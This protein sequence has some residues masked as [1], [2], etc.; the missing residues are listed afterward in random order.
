MIS[1]IKRII[2]FFKYIYDRMLSFYVKKS[3]LSR[4]KTK[5][6]QNIYPDYKLTKEQEKE[7]DDF[8]LENYGTKIPYYSHREH[9]SFMNK[10]HK[11]YF[12]EFIF[13]SETNGYFNLWKEYCPVLSDKNVLPLI[14]KGVG[15]NVPKQIFSCVRGHYRNEN[16]EIITQKEFIKLFSNSGKLFCK[17]SVESGGGNNCFVVDMK[18]GIDEINK[19]SARE[20]VKRL[21]ND[22][23]M[24]NF[25]KCHSS[26]QKLYDKSCNTFRIVTYYWKGKLNIMPVFIRVGSNDA[27][28]DNVSAGGMFIGVKDNGTLEKYGFTEMG[29]KYEKHP[30]TNIVFE[31][32]QI[33]GFFK[34]IEAAKKMHMSLPQIGVAFWD[35][36]LDENNDPLL[37]EVNLED[38]G[39]Y[40]NEMCHGTPALAE[41]TAEVLRWTRLMKK[42]NFVERRKLY[43]KWVCGEE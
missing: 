40:V 15:I 21:G 34:V 33:P 22:F 38:G 3:V 35:F 37:I 36:T 8:Y 30:N 26:L 25:V 1:L 7:I 24:Q 27:V 14:A 5:E 19:L 12:P 32:Y 18:E 23:V 4:Y 39:I 29:V 17:P 13:I 11:D 16:D 28:I 42:S 41:N 9:A 20:I 2:D 6:H 31:G 43:R 10:F